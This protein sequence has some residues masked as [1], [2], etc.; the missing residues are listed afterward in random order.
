MPWSFLPGR[1]HCPPK[2]PTN[3]AALKGFFYVGYAAGGSEVKYK[4]WKE[5]D[6]VITNFGKV[7]TVSYQDGCQVFVNEELQS[8][9][10]PSNLRKAE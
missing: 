3:Q 7:R 8:W 9:Y 6:R 5:G 4:V 2:Y 10:H 1:E